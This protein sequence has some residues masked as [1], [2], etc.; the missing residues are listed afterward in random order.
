MFSVS[1]SD[2]LSAEYLIKYW[3]MAEAVD[4]SELDGSVKHK[5]FEAKRYNRETLTNVID[6]AWVR[7]WKQI[8]NYTGSSLKQWTR[9]A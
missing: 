7:R 4:K 2:I 5:A 6:R 1:S 3:P 9:K 8:V